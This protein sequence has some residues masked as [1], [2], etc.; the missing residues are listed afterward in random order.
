[1]GRNAG[2]SAG[3]GEAVGSGDLEGS[4]GQE[5]GVPAGRVEDAV[6]AAAEDHEVRD[7]GMAA[8]RDPHD[9]MNVAPSWSAVAL[10][11]PAMVIPSDDRF[12]EVGGD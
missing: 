10:P 3:A 6:V 5:F 9:M 11:E 1:M 2:W 8:D 7:D 4:V 12:P